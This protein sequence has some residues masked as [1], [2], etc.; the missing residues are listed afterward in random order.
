MTATGKVDRKRLREIGA[1]FSVESLAEMRTAGQGP[2]RQPTTAAEMLLRETWA[3][4]LRIG[5]AGIGLDDSF[6]HLGGDSI[7]AI[8]VVAEAR[9]MGFGL[10]VADMFRHPTLQG[11]GR[12]MQHVERLSEE[13]IPPFALLDDVEDVASFLGDISGLFHLDPARIVDVYPCAPLQE[14]LFSLASKQSGNYVMQDVL[15]LSPKVAV[16]DLC[17]AWDRVT[18]AMPIL[19]TRMVEHNGGLLQ[20]VM[21]QEDGWIDATGLEGYL[22][23]D[24]KRPMGLGEPLTRFA[25]VRDDTGSP[26]WFVWTMHH[27]IY[28]G[29]SIRLVMA[30]VHRAMQGLSIEQGPQVQAFVKYINTVVPNKYI[31][32]AV[33]NYWVEALAGYRGEPFPALPPSV[34]PPAADTE[35]EHRFRRPRRR[36][37]DMTTATVVHA[38]WALIIGRMSNTE[39]VVFGAT[40]SGRNAPVAGI[41]AMVAPTFATI[42]VRVKVPG[43]RSVSAYLKTVQQQAVDAIP[44]EQAGLH[45]IAVMSPDCQRACAFQSLLVMQPQDTGV[46]VLENWQD[47]GVDVLGTWQATKRQWFNTYA[48]MLDIRPAADTL[49]INASFDSGVLEPWLVH[50]LL[51]RLEFVMKQ[52]DAPGDATLADMVVMTPQ[53]SEQIW[54]WNR[55]VPAP[56]ERCAHQM[57]QDRVLAQPAAPAICAW[58]GELSYRELDRLSSRLV[59]RLVELGVKPN[60]LVPLCFEKSMWTPVAMLGVLKAGGGFVLLDASLPQQRLQ[61]MVGQL[62]AGFIVSSPT[63]LSLSSGLSPAVLQLDPKSMNLLDDAP[64]PAPVQ[65]APTD[66]MFAVFTSGSTGEPKGAVLSHVNF[67]SAL[68][69]QSRLLGLDK[70]SRLFDFASYAFDVAVHNVMATLA[71]GGCVCIPA[72]HERR[73]NISNAMA[74]TGATMAELTPSVARLV[75]PA[76]VPQLNTLILS[77][78]AVSVDDITPWWGKTRLVNAYGPAECGISTIS[79]GQSSPEHVISIGKGAGLVTWVVDPGNHNSLLPPGDV[80]E[81]VLEGPLVGRGYLDDPEKTARSFIE[82]PAWLLQGPPSPG[83]T[84]RHGRLYK[85]GDLVRY[86]EDGSLGFVGRKDAQVKIRGQRVELGE[87]EHWVQHLTDAKHVVAEVVMPRGEGS[88]PALAAFLQMRDEPDAPDLGILTLPVD[89]EDRLTGHLPSYMMPAVFFL[90]RELP[91]TPTGKTDRRRLRE[92]GSSF[93]ER[94]KGVQGPKHE[95]T[96]DAERQM[97]AIWAKVLGIEPGTIGADDGFIKLGGNSI[98][99]MAVAGEARKLGLDVAVADMFRHPK[100]HQLAATVLAGTASTTIPSLAPCQGAEQSFAQQGLWASNRLHPRLPWHLTPWAVRLRGSLRLDALKTA[101]FVLERRHDALRTTFEA[102]GGVGMQRIRPFQDK[103]LS[104]VDVSP[105]AQGLELALQRTTPFDLEAEPGWRVTVYRIDEQEHVLSVV[106]HQIAADGWSLDLVRRELAVFYSAA[107]DGQDPLA[108]VDSLPIQ[109]RDYSAWQRQPSQMRLQRRQLDYW[110]GQLGTSRPAEFPC[111]HPR[112]ETLSGET[113]ALETR[114]DGRLHDELQRFCRERQVTLFVVL[115]AAFRGAHCRLTGATDATV[116]T[117]SANRDRW[118]TR[119]LVGPL[120]NVQCI[121]IKVENESFDEL[122]RQVQATTI[123]SFANQHVPFERVV[124]ELQA[125]RDRSRHPLVQTLFAVHARSSLES[126]ALE[127]VETEQI[128]LPVTSRFD[129]EFHLYQEEEAVRGSLIFSTDLY[130]SETIGNVL[131][132]FRAVLER[133]LADPTLQLLYP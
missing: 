75:D 3:R 90:V 26:R 69:H 119:E 62:D 120:V 42:P 108:Q 8:K 32:T 6:F 129:I 70:D 17:S 91:L 9:K 115:L 45:R 125:D 118:E 95:P 13:H 46:D 99:A 133:G 112:P 84:G 103:E 27:A 71:S 106:T 25:L 72:D 54:R 49:V 123:T 28:D 21:D 14:G 22:E 82:D 83:Q 98:S 73:D 50:R 24:R 20:V 44:H 132:V 101:L 121:R 33:P 117:A 36:L 11:L 114:I 109:Y 96:S 107:L 51:T 23:A 29:W 12:Q 35:A 52:L 64:R 110:T 56:M 122:V 59:G 7:A 4:V 80:G 38:A 92:L 100:L 87:V 93:K 86:H 63:T 34:A 55:V 131:S 57:I 19:R 31:D 18:R 65:P 10:A 128:A 41:D 47:T 1:L 105:D 78:E 76:T 74:R 68:K 97:Q 79:R 16:S 89:V 53:D 113:A 30:A 2:K 116:G 127:G 58:D 81:L 124:S 66:A 94:I 39:D 85:T 111:D 60:V 126:F 48:L 37:T 40:V 43:H 15:Q 104:V 67:C 61:N 77:G 102:Q 88:S 5:P 130:A